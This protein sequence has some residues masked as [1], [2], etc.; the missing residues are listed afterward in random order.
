MHGSEPGQPLIA[1]RGITRSFQAGDET[2]TVLDNVDIEIRA[3]EMV[4]IIGASG[5][6]KSTL[7]NILGCLDRPSSGRYL[8]DG[9]DISALD[10]DA[11]AELRREH[12]GFIFQRYQLL[13]DLDAVGNVEVPAVYAGEGAA[14]RRARAMDL[15]RRL[16]LGDRLDHRPSALSGGQQQRVSVARALMN[17]GEVILADEPTGA[18]DSSSGEEL[19]AL[20]LDLNRQGHTVVMVTHDPRV[21]AHAHRVIE[22]RDGRIVSDRPTA[23]APRADR[24]D[25]PVR[26][27]RAGAGL[28]RQIEAL[29]MAARALLAH[30]VRSLLTMLGIIIGIAS[31]V[32]VVAL[33][34]GSQQKVLEN[35]S[36][37]GTSTIT[38]R[39]GSG[40]GARDA[41]RF[42]TLV[43]SDA[44]ALALQDFADSVSPAVSDSLSVRYRNVTSTASIGGVSGDYFQVHAYTTLQG[45]VFGP[46]DIAA[47][48][49]VA[50]ID[51][52]TRDTFFGTGADPLGEVLLL[53]RVPVRVIGLVRA[54]GATFGPSSLNVWIPYTTSMARVSGQDH[55][56]SIAVRV[57]DGYDMT[58][59]QDAISALMLTRHGSRDFF[60]TNSDSIRETITSTTRTLTALVAMIAVI[61]LIV[62]G[63]GVMNIML[64]SVT[65]R[66]REI[67]VRIAIGARRSDIVA[68]FLI[69]AVLVCLVGGVLGIAG[70]L[71]TGEIVDRVATEV[72]LAFSGTAIA[73]A[74]LSSTL[75]GITFGFLPAR[76]AAR[77]DPVVA[78]SRE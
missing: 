25:R 66:T 59:A 37:L 39:S 20:L 51:E 4:A 58:R 33:G 1:A 74:F 61:S 45:T 8:F 64:V 19:M 14:P 69:E 60:L 5:S 76:A 15:L 27:I 31:V 62:G 53:G 9:Q 52:D 56:S 34:N 40:F 28:R 72:R 17:G 65:E 6:G 18:L 78:L 42:E 16:G 36:S 3:G 48:E 26:Q 57:A 46:E 2:I 67:G 43:P 44:D 21:A 10:P 77:L 47:R 55:F 63:I 24:P 29:S 11:L 71:L 13:P 35:I 70:A 7:M 54:T 41:N 68:Q 49:Q 30:R 38:I 75:I 32:L 22:I 73:V 50:V 12:F 23:D